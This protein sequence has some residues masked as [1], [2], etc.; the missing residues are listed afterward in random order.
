M[1]GPGGPRHKYRGK[2]GYAPPEVI[3]TGETID[4]YAVDIWSLGVTLFVMLTGR[5]LY[6][7]PNDAAFA[8]LA[9]G[10]TRRLLDHY[11][12]FGL[13]VEP[14]AKDLLCAML[15]PNPAQRPTVEQILDNPWVAA[16]HP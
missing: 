7:D 15:N 12:G 16:W 1:G 8:V 11:A 10:S 4:P 14:L 5:P 13:V 6:T 2:L 9:Q 3:E